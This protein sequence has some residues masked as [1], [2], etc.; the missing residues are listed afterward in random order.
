LA[1]HE[2][3]HKRSKKQSNPALANIPMQL[4]FS[5]NI[6]PAPNKQFFLFGSRKELLPYM[7]K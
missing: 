3:A 2:S 1:Y 6:S 7:A 5:K 4:F